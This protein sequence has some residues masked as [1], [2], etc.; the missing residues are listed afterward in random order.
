MAIYM[1]HYG[2]VTNWEI[3][4]YESGKHFV[5]DIFTSIFF[6][7]SLKASHIMVSA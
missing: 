7:F 1:K 5:F 2:V 6:F 3:K 4:A